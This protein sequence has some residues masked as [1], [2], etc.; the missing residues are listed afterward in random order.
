MFIFPTW[1]SVMIIS[2]LENFYANKETK[3]DQNVLYYCKVNIRIFIQINQ[4]REDL[5][6]FLFL[7][8]A[9]GVAR[10]TVVHS[11]LSSSRLLSCW[12][13][14]TASLWILTC[15]AILTNKLG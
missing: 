8:M 11:F 10:L 4:L 13:S 6:L 14:W 15:W 2:G 1:R 12:C 3:T 5:L 7:A 9:A